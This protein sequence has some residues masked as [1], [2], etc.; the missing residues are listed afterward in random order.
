MI[1][2]M[3]EK[4]EYWVEEELGAW[5]RGFSGVEMLETGAACLVFKAF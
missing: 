3:Q 1:A 2:M 4:L 5:T